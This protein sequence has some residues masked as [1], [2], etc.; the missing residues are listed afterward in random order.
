MIGRV[1]AAVEDLLASGILFT[2]LPVAKIAE[3]S[4]IPRSSFYQYFPSKSQV[5]VQ[6]AE[7]ASEQFFAAPSA[8]FARPDT[9]E[10]GVAGVEE[11][12]ATMLAEYRKHRT[13]MRA[14][15]ELSSYDTDVADFWLGLINDHIESMA[16]TVARWQADGIVDPSVH[17]YG[18]T[19]ALV[20]MVERSICQHVLRPVEGRELDDAELV[21]ALARS[22]W[23]S[24]FAPTA[25]SPDSTT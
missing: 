19:T 18:A 6:V 25:H 2:E 4:G 1:L 8:W 21:S 10:E 5:L 23:L 9:H 11:V 20:W 12:M 17:P 16:T 24:Y 3:Q 22:I 13:V 7:L 15:D 14:L